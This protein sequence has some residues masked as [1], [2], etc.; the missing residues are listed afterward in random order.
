MTPE[1]WRQVTEIFHAALVRDEPDRAAV[2]VSRCGDDAGLRREV[3]SMLAAHQNAGRFGETPL[4]AL[5]A[6]ETLA[7]HR[8]ALSSGTKLGV[9][10]ILSLIGCGGMG[11]VYRAR[12]TQLGRDVAIKV[13]PAAFVRD[14]E[15]LARF[16]REARMLAAL[17]HPHIGTIY[18]VEH[19][20][21][22]PALVLELVDGETL[23][24]RIAHG[25][26]AITEA[27]PIARQ[28]A[29]ALEAAHEKGIVHRDL[30]PA[31]IKLTSAGAVKV[32]DFGLAKAGA[33]SAPEASHAPTVTVAGT[34]DGVL[35]GTAAY[36]S[37]E[38]AR[39][40][41]VDK[42]T[43]IWAFGCVLYEMLTGTR[44]FADGNVAGTLA[45]VLTHDPDWAPLPGNMPAPLRILLRRCFEKDRRLR[46]DSAADARLEIQDALAIHTGTKAP[47]V[48]SPAR[49]SQSR[50][51][52]A[53]L[54]LG[55]LAV[56]AATIF[57]LA[58]RG[59]IAPLTRA[60]PDAIEARPVQ[61]SI[62]PPEDSSFG[63]VPSEPHP[64]LSPDG[65]RVAFVATSPDGKRRIWIRD[66]D[67]SVP[68]PLAAT[69]GVTGTPFW[70]PDG[71]FIG[72]F[73]QGQLKKIR[74]AGGP[75]ET[76][77][78]A[79]GAIAGAWS[80]RGDI[81]F[82]GV[83]DGL[84][85]VPANGG[86]SEYVTQLD[87]SRSETSHRYPQFL[88]DGRHFLYLVRSTG[89]HRGTFVGSLG[90][91]DRKRVLADDTAVAYEPS[92]S[93]STGSGHLLFVRETTLMAQPFDADRLEVTGEAVPVAADVPVAPT[94]RKAP[95]S[96]AG[97][98]LVYRTAGLAVT[99][100]VWVD[101]SWQT[102]RNGWPARHLQPS[103]SVV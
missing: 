81:L 102:P 84:R 72:L 20:G 94:G 2:V 80:Q 59:V 66:V 46:L 79:P 74:P 69:S 39:G 76:L 85:R 47:D 50:R 71:R 30:K 73:A 75:P 37:P 100:L 77:C 78:E 25:P 44:A 4:F 93:G 7:H 63:T 52:T 95:F 62:L 17:N 11:E 13:L 35:L 31:N 34:H 15:R 86:T 88:S 68:R 49:T 38:Q 99:Q 10:E 8:M 6:G 1:R 53:L 91:Q 9:Y 36:M 5:G 19:V 58:S 87:R 14:R 55:L 22:V 57:G 82:A 51:M 28:I 54:V 18:G 29:E 98:T 33:G 89:E 26:I 60:G 24:D 61:F 21:G 67:S 64:T 96:V 97:G 56:A 40:H 92:S 101:W 70:S 42:R 23:A 43:D 27:L 45:R 90:S 41:A 65:R 83:D 48:M 12:D 32:L 103:S 3:E 16:E